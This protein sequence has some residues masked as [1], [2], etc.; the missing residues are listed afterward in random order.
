MVELANHRLVNLPKAGDVE[1]VEGVE[2][3]EEIQ[4]LNYFNP[5]NLFNY[6]NYFPG[7]NSSTFFF[8]NT[9]IPSSCFLM[10]RATAISP[11]N[12]RGAL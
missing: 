9:K 8:L 10:K 4:N 1:E 11:K 5:L 7:N 12:P 6:L 2:E 3:V